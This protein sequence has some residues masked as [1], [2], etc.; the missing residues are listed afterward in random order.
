MLLVLQSVWIAL[1]G[2]L[3]D[4]NDGVGVFGVREIVEEFFVEFWYCGFVLVGYMGECVYYVTL[5][6]GR[7]IM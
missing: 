2:L 1:G 7:S 6:L 5:S 3:V 4:G